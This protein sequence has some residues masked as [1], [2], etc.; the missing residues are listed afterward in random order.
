[1]SKFVSKVPD[2]DNKA[3]IELSRA[4]SFNCSS[5]LH[6]QNFPLISK[7]QSANNVYVSL[8]DFEVLKLLG[9][10]SFGK[11][12]LVRR[13]TD[14]SQLYAMKVLKKDELEARKQVINTKTERIILS[15]VNHPNIIRIKYAF[16]TVDKLYMILEYCAGGEIFYHLQMAKRF[17]EKKARFYAANVILA[18]EHFHS[19]QIIYR[20]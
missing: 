17:G 14:S 12:L 8:S 4:E 10:G 15:L 1:V 19:K 7:S 11:V 2:E 13:K 20:E 16:Q 5:P 6:L 9:K 18:I 3:S